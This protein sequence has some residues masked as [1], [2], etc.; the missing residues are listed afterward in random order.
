MENNKLKQEKQCD[1]HDVNHSYI[2]VISRFELD[3]KQDGVFTTVKKVPIGEI[4]ETTVTDDKNIF[5]GNCTVEK[6]QKFLDE[7][8]PNHLVLS[9]RDYC[10]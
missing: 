3:V 10:L 4:Q 7:K 9:V 6:A 1:I 8:Y 2:W 5:K